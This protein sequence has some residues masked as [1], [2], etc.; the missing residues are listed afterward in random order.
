[1]GICRSTVCQREV[2]LVVEADP[3]EGGFEAAY[4]QVEALLQLFGIFSLAA[5]TVSHAV[6][7]LLQILQ[8]NCHFKIVPVIEEK[9]LCWE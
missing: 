2:L 7:F 1:V 9:I 5:G 4:Q 3:G 8:S 6:I